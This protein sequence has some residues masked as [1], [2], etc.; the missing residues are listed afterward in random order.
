[1]WPRMSALLSFLAY[2]RE[3]LMVAALAALVV[4]GTVVALGAWVLFFRQGR[5]SRR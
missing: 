2:D 5:R 3:D 1:M 4:A